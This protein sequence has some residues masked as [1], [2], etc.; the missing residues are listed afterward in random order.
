MVFI[1]PLFEKISCHFYEQEIENGIEIKRYYIGFLD[2]KSY[3]ISCDG[4]M[5]KS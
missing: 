5:L 2:D 3:R 4:L 1:T